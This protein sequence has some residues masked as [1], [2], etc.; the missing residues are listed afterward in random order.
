MKEIKGVYS[1]RCAPVGE[2][3]SIRCTYG[4]AS[5]LVN[6]GRTHGGVFFSAPL[7]VYM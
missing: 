6:S 3:V 1:F 5:W 4:Y 2:W 7:K